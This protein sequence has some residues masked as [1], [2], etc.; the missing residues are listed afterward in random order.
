MSE[1]MHFRTTTLEKTFSVS[2]ATVFA[3]WSDLDT[4][5]RWNSPSEEVKIKYTEDDFSVGGKD[6]S[7]CLVGDHVVAEVVG[8]YHDIVPDQRIVYT[9]IIKSGEGDT[10][11]VSQVSVGFTPMGSGT[12]MVVTLQ[13]VA[14]AGPEVLDDVA[15]G[16]TASLGMMEKVLAR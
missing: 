14:L 9:E 15:A 12:G 4:R 11:G 10:L 3:A 5:S 1:A 7:L 6:V 16:W 8:I 13:T 2:V